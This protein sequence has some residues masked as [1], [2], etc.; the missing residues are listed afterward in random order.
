MK[1]IYEIN[2]SGVELTEAKSILIIGSL[3]ILIL[4][5]GLI[6]F[7]IGMLPERNTKDEEGKILS[8]SY[9]KYLRSTLWFVEWILLIAILFI[10]SNVAS[11]YL[12]I[13]LISGILFKLFYICFA[14]TP[15]VVIV[16]MIWIIVS[17]FH[18]K[19]FQRLL[20]RGFFP[21]V[22]L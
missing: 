5:M 8:I 2:P 22:N 18:D 4:F 21:Q 7:G 11:A 3:A 15:L 20:N 17:M 13:T 16:C 10:S 6:F 14:L 1:G 19:Q 12:G 9:L